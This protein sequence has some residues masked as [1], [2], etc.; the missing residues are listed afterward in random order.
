MKW[1]NEIIFLILLIG[2]ISCKHDKGYPNT[3]S[4]FAYDPN[5]RIGKWYSISDVGITLPS[6]NAR[7]DT[8]WFISDTLAGWTG[9]KTD[10]HQYV[11]W[12]TYID[13]KSIY[14]LIYLAPDYMD[15]TKIDTISHQFG[16]NEDTMTIY[17]NFWT[18]PPQTERYL[19]KK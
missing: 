15:T 1:N 11:F 9:F 4:Q 5:Y 8:V 19:K 13:P 7:L 14:N 12:K 16:F 6:Y 10:Q 2:L 18:T 17:W 3:Q